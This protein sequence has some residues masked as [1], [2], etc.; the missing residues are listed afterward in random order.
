MTLL[1]IIAFLSGETVDLQTLVNGCPANSCTIKLEAKTYTANKINVNNLNLTIEAS[2]ES[3]LDLSEQTNPA[4]LLVGSTLKMTQ[5]TIKP[6][7]TAVLVDGRDSSKVVLDLCSFVGTELSNA[8]LYGAKSSLTLKSIMMNKMSLKSSFIEADPAV[9][10]PDMSITLDHCEFSQLDASTSRPIVSGERILTTTILGGS[11]QNCDCTDQS[12]LPATTQNIPGREVRIVDTLFSRNT[13]PL[14]GLLTFGVQAARLYMSDVEYSENENSVR[15]SN[16]VSFTPNSVIEILY[17]TSRGSSTTDLWPSGG[18]LY[19]PSTTTTLTINNTKFEDN[20]AKEHG[21]SIY[22]ATEKTVALHSVVTSSCVAGKDGGFLYF[23]GHGTLD[24]FRVEM[25]GN[26]A[27]QNGGSLFL[28]DYA[29]LNIYAGFMKECSAGE[30]GGA[31]AL[32]LQKGASTTFNIVAFVNN[33][34]TGGLGKDVLA[35]T[36]DKGK[37][38]TKSAFV[39]CTSST[40]NPMVTLMPKKE[41]YNWSNSFATWVRNW[42]I[43][44]VVVVV[45]VVVLSIVLPCVCCCCGCGAACVGAHKSNKRG[46]SHVESQPGY[47]SA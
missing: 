11:F 44:I 42:V 34:A 23:A 13:G 30:N 25:T 14:S 26:K 5:V 22:V 12:P 10:N 33:E 17:A 24:F 16:C 7:P 35:T 8:L 19:L 39:R 3:Q 2:E 31:V 18:F 4:F 41:H 21:G 45:V 1:F 43:F 20:T 9:A 47:G 36:T 28:A 6:S 29:K 32:T 37:K 38:L 15:F 27:K 40:N 46:Y